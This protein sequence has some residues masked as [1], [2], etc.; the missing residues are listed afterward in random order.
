MLKLSVAT[1]KDRMNTAGCIK[2]AVFFLFCLSFFTACPLNA[3]GIDSELVPFVTGGRLYSFNPESEQDDGVLQYDFF[4]MAD[5]F[6]Q[7]GTSASKKKN[8]IL[9]WNQKK[10]R[11]YHIT[12]QKLV[13]NV[14]LK[15]SLVYAGSDYILAQSSSFEDK[16][17]FSF[18]LYSIKYSLNGRKI[19]LRT[20]WTGFVDCFVSDFF[21]TADGVCIAGGN[22]DD[23]KNNSFYITQKGIHKCFSVA[24][25]SDFLRLINTGKGKDSSVVY[26]FLSGREKSAAQPVIY[27]FNLESFA[28]GEDPSNQIDLSTDYALPSGFECFFGYGFSNENIILPASI[29]GIIQFVCYDCDSGKITDIIPDAV[30][31]TG[32]LS[33]TADGTYYIARDPLIEGSWYGIALFDGTECKKIA[34]FF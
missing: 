11:L 1:A 15:A 26:A 17:G 13:S 12:G 22:R 21:F 25:N 27:K 18:T 28:E 19:K 32:V 16:K 9:A 7:N 20:V 4:N 29:N 8:F 24:K 34:K 3:S 5:G 23:T 30:G 10:Q 31:C 6:T 14:E 33:G 2:L